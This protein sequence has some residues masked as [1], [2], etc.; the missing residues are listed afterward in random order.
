MLF[1]RAVC[2]PPS[3]RGRI[4]LLVVSREAPG[5]AIRDGEVRD[6]PRGVEKTPPSSVVPGGLQHRRFLPGE[7]RSGRRRR[8]EGFPRYAVEERNPVSPR[9]S[10][11]RH[12]ASVVLSGAVVCPFLRILVRRLLLFLIAEIL[13]YECCATCIPGEPVH[14]PCHC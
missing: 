12:G 2:F 11:P 5:A 3:D 7:H 8:A 4:V 13:S 9:E 10:V 14:P 6:A 1:V